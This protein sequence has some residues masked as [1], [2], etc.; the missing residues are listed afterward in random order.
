MTHPMCADPLST[1]PTAKQLV[2]VKVD[3]WFKLGQQLGLT[4]DQLESFKRSPQPTAATFL[5]AKAKNIDLNLK[6][7]V[8]SLLFVGEYKVA[9]TVC[10][11]QG[12]LFCAFHFF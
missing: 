8:E 9:E 11:Q 5:A 3:K 7:V 10:S 6:H 4:E 2:E 1:Y 12:S